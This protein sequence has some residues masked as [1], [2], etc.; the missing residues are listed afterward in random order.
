MVESNVLVV[1]NNIIRKIAYM[2]TAEKRRTQ[3]CDEIIKQFDFNKIHVVEYQLDLLSTDITSFRKFCIIA[4]TIIVVL[5]CDF[6]YFAS[7]FLHVK[8]LMLSMLNTYAAALAQIENVVILILVLFIQQVNAKSV[9]TA[10]DHEEM[11]KI[12]ADQNVPYGIIVTGSNTPDY[13]TIHNID[14]R[15]STVSI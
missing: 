3:L 4:N 7:Y 15:Q 1:L 14:V 11:M 8:F 6:L 9:V 2:W 10:E 12:C 13:V 5:F